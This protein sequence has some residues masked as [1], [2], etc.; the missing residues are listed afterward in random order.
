M[1]Y[2]CKPPQTKSPSYLIHQPYGYL[3]R[4]MVP[5]DLRPLVGKMESPYAAKEFWFSRGNLGILVHRILEKMHTGKTQRK[6][7]TVV[8]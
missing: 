2:S 7:W 1:A 4:M 5:K 6:Y 8:T 3:F